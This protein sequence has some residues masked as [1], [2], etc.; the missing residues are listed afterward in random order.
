MKTKI[1]TIS[2]MTLILSISV[3]AVIAD[4]PEPDVSDWKDPRTRDED[5]SHTQITVKTTRIK[6]GLYLY[7]YSIVS[8]PENKGTIGSFKLDVSCDL[9]FSTVEFPPVEPLRDSSRD[10]HVPVGNVHISRANMA[11]YNMSLKPGEQTV[12]FL[13][14]PAPPTERAYLLAVDMDSEG[15]RY[16]LYP[17][18]KWTQDFIVRGT[19]LGPECTLDFGPEI[20]YLGAAEEPFGVN[21]LLAYAEPVTDELVLSNA[22][23]S[24]TVTLFYDA[25]ADP[26]TFKAKLDG[27][28]ISALFNPVPDTY[29]TVVISGDWKINSRIHLSILGTVDD[30][31]KGNNKFKS[32]DNDVFKVKVVK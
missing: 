1:L 17:E 20:E 7:G 23:E 21:K 13:T 2:G 11:Y 19:V 4:E 24:V 26:S 8:P 16:D 14:S 32:I 18:G 31:N 6:S 25:K 3:S 9:D 29:E 10:P 28:D 5:I 30:K 12:R 27:K 15:W 22:A